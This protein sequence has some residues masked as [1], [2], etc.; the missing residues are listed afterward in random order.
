MPEALGLILLVMLRLCEGVAVSELLTDAVLDNEGVCEP[1]VDI[2]GVTL[3]D[4]DCDAVKLGV[5]AALD[6][7]LGEPEALA[8]LD[9]ERV[10]VRDGETDADWLGDCVWLDVIE[11]VDVTDPLVD[12]EACDDGVCVHDWL[13]VTVTDGVGEHTSL[14]PVR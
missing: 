11:S 12:G 13:G 14:C 3:A 1:D 6:V 5:G 4:T 8:V 9:P 7:R 10:C 2:L